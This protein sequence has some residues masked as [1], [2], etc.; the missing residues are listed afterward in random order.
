MKN[1]EITMLKFDNAML[2]LETVE[3][4]DMDDLCLGSSG[5]DELV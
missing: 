4:V 2:W 1:S 5:E 3:A